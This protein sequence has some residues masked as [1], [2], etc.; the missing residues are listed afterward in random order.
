MTK[1]NFEIVL[2]AVEKNQRA[3]GREISNWLKK[4]G[5][6]RFNSK[7]T[8]QILYRLLSSEIV[9]RDGTGDKPRWSVG[10]TWGSSNTSEPK[11]NVVLRPLS[12]RETE[13]REYK[14]ASTLV[15]VILENDLSSNDPYMSPDWVGTH[16][17]A[18]I[19][20]NHPFWTLR[21]GAASEKSLFSMIAALDA[22]VQ[23]RVAQLSEL[24]DAT[25]ILKIRDQA[26]R[27]CTLM[28]LEVPTDG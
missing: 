16:V 19:N 11:G 15:K 23:W 24:P 22:Y 3:T 21:L 1:T 12:P 7:L 18:A 26:L 5:Q 27:F 8:N 4:N 28:E 10:Q 13:V 25:E 6:P 20:T 9:D 17:V 2:E 14:I